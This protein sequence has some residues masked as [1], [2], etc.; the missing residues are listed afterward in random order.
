MPD[1]S[2]QFLSGK[3]RGLVSCASARDVRGK[4]ARSSAFRSFF[5]SGNLALTRL[6][7]NFLYTL[8]LQQ[9]RAEGLWGPELTSSAA[10]G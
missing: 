3:S 10:V 8:F 9:T 5:G 4:G 6:H 1:K 2:L 7:R